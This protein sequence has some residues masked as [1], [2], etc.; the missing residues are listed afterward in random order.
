[1][2]EQRNEALISNRL[3]FR[4]KMKEIMP[5]GYTWAWGILLD[6]TRYRETKTVL[7]HLP[8]ESTNKQTTK[9]RV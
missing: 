9:S 1:M 5:S 4:H 6:Y 2:K 7:S 8:V 3:L